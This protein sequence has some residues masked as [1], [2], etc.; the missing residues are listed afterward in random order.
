ML[1]V[2]LVL[3]VSL[4]Y[5]KM[6][7][8]SGR[9]F[10][11]KTT[12]S[13]QSSPE[14]ILFGKGPNAFYKYYM[15]HQA[16]VLEGKP[17]EVRQRADNIHHPLSE[18]LM[19]YVNY[20][21]IAL[22]SISIMFFV[23]FYFLRKDSMAISILL[24]II[25]FSLF[26][27]PFRYPLAWISLAWC[28]SRIRF[29]YGFK[30]KNGFLLKCF[31]SFLG[32]LLMLFSTREAYYNH[33]WKKAVDNSLLGQKCKSIIYYD[34]VY[35]WLNNDPKFQYNYALFLLKNDQVDNAL[36]IILQCCVNDYDT[37]MIK[38]EIFSSKGQASDAI[39]HY[40]RASN[41]CPNRF[42]PLFA[43]Y[44]EYCNASDTV[45]INYVRKLIIDKPVK[46]PSPIINHIKKEMYNQ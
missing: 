32:I 7:S 5:T 15:L 42:I 1:L 17:E 4:F 16:V 24:T 10:I 27:Y 45:Q 29:K 26:S 34:K 6:E 8:T 21:A 37:E 18:F 38:G 14:E 25:V 11:Y 43:L 33:I 12:L 23:F 36:K 3:F 22:C 30:L 31:A 39:L 41:M 2:S 46:I 44:K 9:F 19:I 13:L 20:G 35:D 28:A 40:Q